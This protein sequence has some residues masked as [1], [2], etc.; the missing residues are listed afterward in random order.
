MLLCHDGLETNSWGSYT[1]ERSGTETFQQGN[2][3][4]CVVLV[5]L[6][7]ENSLVLIIHY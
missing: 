3:S 5:I 6:V 2:R 7:F 1:I 4:L